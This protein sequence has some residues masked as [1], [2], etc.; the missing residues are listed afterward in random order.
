MLSERGSSAQMPDTIFIVDD[1]EAVRDSLKLLL[2]SYGLVVADFGSTAEFARHY[3]PGA[4]QC[5][6]LD[7]HLPGSTGLDFLASPAGAALELPVILVTGR[8]D[9]ALRA[10]AEALGVVRYLEKP[11]NDDVLLNAI[12]AA[13]DG[14]VS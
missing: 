12:R 5:L 4:R 10:R 13:V 6:V 11:V 8:G 3:R 1:D 14:A 7:Q 2:E 9:K